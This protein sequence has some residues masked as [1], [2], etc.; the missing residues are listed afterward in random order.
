MILRTCLA[1]GSLFF[2]LSS[3]NNCNAG[4]SH[5]TPI[6]QAIAGG[7][8]NSLLSSPATGSVFPGPEVPSPLPCYRY[9][10][11]PARGNSRRSNTCS[12]HRAR[13]A[14]EVLCCWWMFEERCLV[15]PQYRH[16]RLGSHRPTALLGG[17]QTPQTGCLLFLRYSI[18]GDSGELSLQNSLARS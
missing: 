17:S 10:M 7:N 15:R 16:S 1:S 9:A 18:T 13:A 12:S 3:W 6:M 11:I 5:A 2:S 4:T 8:V 14:V